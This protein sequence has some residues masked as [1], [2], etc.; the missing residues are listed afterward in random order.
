MGSL[1]LA[2][3][4]PLLTPELLAKATDSIVQ[5]RDGV[6]RAAMPQ[7][8]RDVRVR[9]RP[10]PGRAGRST[11]RASRSWSARYPHGGAGVDVFR[12]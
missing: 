10:G 9:Q 3:D 6:L 1:G 2:L 8:D 7:P 5:T 4:S 11:R 12:R